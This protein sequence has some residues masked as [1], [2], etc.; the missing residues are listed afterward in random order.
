MTTPTTVERR[1]VPGVRLHAGGFQEDR[2]AGL[3]R[4]LRHVRGQ[5]GQS[6]SRRCTRARGTRARWA[7]VVKIDSQRHHRR[8]AGAP[9]RRLLKAVNASADYE[10]AASLRGSPDIQRLTATWHRVGLCKSVA[11]PKPPLR[12]LAGGSCRATRYSMP[13]D[14]PERGNPHRAGDGI[15][16]RP[17]K[18]KSF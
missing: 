4:V 8:Q 16:A 5:P 3:Q 17:K 12:T 13:R 2:P 7:R 11:T 15:P 18:P 9:S 10:N 1:E 6:A 14:P